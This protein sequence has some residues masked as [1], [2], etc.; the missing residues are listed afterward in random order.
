MSTF[1]FGL[2]AAS[3]LTAFLLIVALYFFKGAAWAGSS[4]AKSGVAPVSSGELAARLESINSLDVPFRIE[5]GERDGE[6]IAT[7]R[8][9]DA[10]WI[11]LAR[12]HGLRRVHRIKLALDPGSRTVRATDFSASY[13]WSAGRGGASLQWKSA[14]GI[15]FFQQDHHRVFGLQLD[16][17]GRFK[18]ELSYAYT[19]NLQE[20]KQP[21]I[22][23]VTQAGWTWRPVLWQGPKWMRWLTE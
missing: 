3:G 15:I 4:P 9:A 11:D 7:W 20:M 12:A 16:E 5:R 23:A 14:T 19:F 22:A 2:F 17:Q 10:K 21:L 8:Y 6:F 18:P 1:S 13:D